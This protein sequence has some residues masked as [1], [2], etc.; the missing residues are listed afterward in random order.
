M[1]SI[2]KTMMEIKGFHLDY[3]FKNSYE[4]L[5][6]PFNKNGFKEKLRF[7]KRIAIDKVFH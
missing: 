5:N 6:I 2:P 4:L 3:I 7:Y 1:I